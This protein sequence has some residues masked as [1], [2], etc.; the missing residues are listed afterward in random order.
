MK[1]KVLKFG[2]TSVADKTSR[3]T[4]AQRVADAKEQGFAPVAVISAIGRKGAPYATDTLIGELNQV[5]ADIPANVRDL[6]LLMICGEVISATIFAQGLRAL[7]LEAATVTG[8]QAGIKTDGTYGNGRIISVDASRLKALIEKGVVPV[9]CGFQGSSNADE[10][11]LTTLGRGGTD[12]TA[13]AVGAALG[14]CAVEIYTDVDGIKTADPDSVPHAPTLRTASYDEVAELA[15]LGA[16]VLHPRAA[17]IAMR[18]NIPL[19]VKNS[20]SGDPGTEIVAEDVSYSRSFTGITHSGKL[21]YLQFDLGPVSEAERAVVNQKLFSILS[22]FGVSLY[23]LNVS[24]TSVDFAVERK[25]YPQVERLLD[26]MVLPASGRTYLL[27]LGPASPK[28]QA[29]LSMLTD[30]TVVCADRTEGCTMVSVVGR[31]YFGKPGVFY[32]VL[33]LLDKERIQ[34]LQT[35]D[36]DFSVSCLIP[37]TETYRAVR[38]LHDDLIPA[39]VSV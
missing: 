36:S 34:V 16:K 8:M 28:V 23:M 26:G 25:Q 15:H 20:F 27:Q 9:V 11:E 3:A 4:A 29:Q 30:V 12:T 6:D 24:A 39:E 22:T 5:N 31:S 37:E 13:A 7:G 35:S 17:E 32:R 2:G 33:S 14:A 1:I 10:H 21:V 19:W 18:H 38:V